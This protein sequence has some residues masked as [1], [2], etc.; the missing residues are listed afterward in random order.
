MGSASTISWT[1]PS[2]M[3]AYALAGIVV[4]FYMR[5]MGEMLYIE[6]TTGSF[7]IFAHQYIHHNQ[8]NR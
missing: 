4:F 8:H 3:L 6:S 1:G 5:V 2:V 7:A